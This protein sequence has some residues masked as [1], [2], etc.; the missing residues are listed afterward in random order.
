MVAPVRWATPGTEVAWVSQPW[1]SVSATIQSTSTPPPWPPIASTAIA[2]GC[3]ASRRCVATVSGLMAST[4]GSG[5][6]QPAL[7]AP[8]LQE[9]DDRLAPSG[10]DAGPPARV[11]DAVGAAE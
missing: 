2:I 5:E 4:S 9:A 11:A 10:D 7:R 3:R 8:P 1:F 6:L